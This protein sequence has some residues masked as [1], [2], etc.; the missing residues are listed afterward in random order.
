MG[1]SNRHVFGV[2][3]SRLSDM[4]QS[5]LLTGMLR[6]AQ[7]MN[8]DLLILSS[9]YNPN[10]PSTQLER[11]NDIYD[12]ICSD[13]FDGFILISEAFINPQLQKRILCLL[14]KMKQVPLIALGTPLPGFTLKHFQFLNTSDAMDYEQITDHLIE[15][16]GFR[17]IDML[18]GYEQIEAS[19]LR[20]AGYRASLERHGIPYCPEKVHFGDFWLRSG[21]ELAMD[22]IDGKKPFPQA[23][24]CGNDHM[25]YSMLDTFTKHGISV[26]ERITVTGYEYIRER[27]YHYPLLTTY[28]RNRAEL[29]AEAVR[30]MQQRLDGETSEP[31]M[32]PS[33]R[34]IP[35]H[36]CACGPDPMQ[37]L[38]EQEHISMERTYDFLSLFGQ[39]E[40]EL[41][42]C[43]TIQDMLQVCRE[44]RYMLQNAEEVYLCLYED[45]YSDRSI[46]ENVTCYSLISEARPFTMH[47]HD[48][49]RLCSGPAAAYSICPLFFLQHSLGYAVMKFH[50]ARA[51]TNQYRRWLKAVGNGLEFLRMKN[52]IQYLTQCCNLSETVDIMTDMYNKRGFHSA[53]D[54]AAGTFDARNTHLVVL[55][56]CLFD[57]S[58]A[59][60]S[61]GQKIQA[62]LAA[63]DAVKCF[64]A[65]SRLY[66]RI[67]ENTFACVV[68]CHTSDSKLLE[69]LLGA[70]LIRTPGYTVRYALD[71]FVCTALPCSASSSFPC[72]MAAAL[73]R[74][75]QHTKA[76]AARRICAHYSEM[77]A[78]RNQF[79]LT[80]EAFFETASAE[81]PCSYSSGHL[82]TIYKKC[83]G[84]NPHRDCIDGRLLLAKYLLFTTND[85]I[86]QIAQA[87]G[88]RD[89]K[90]FLRQFRINTEMTPAEYRK[91]CSPAG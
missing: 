42:E 60:E 23:V 57:E 24:V 35:G 17:D 34:L 6:Q 10:E 59:T 19:H 13:A 88:Y 61:S 14:S 77:L 8:I 64:C 68:R 30:L 49:S 44:Y 85:T 65:G 55:R 43:R 84:T 62:I 87:C 22:Y 9:I 52:D 75:E 25:A 54:A 29:G 67:G 40:F 56:V 1:K 69:D 3:A 27:M 89:N 58:Y 76:V 46:S 73:Q 72:Q 21:E 7:E 37:L 70:I 45:W 51:C 31:F 39:L 81:M 20:V 91:A 50:T 11:E 48:L 74:L 63:S 5:D 32:P 79:Y 36:S 82:R 38:A 18:T 78:L 47:K 28:Q 71:S 33:G 90:Y 16:H 83:F 4:E 53:F 15:K 80:P 12:L 86:Q 26:P 41:T 2:I 66:G